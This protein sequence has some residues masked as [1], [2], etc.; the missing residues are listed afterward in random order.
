V[1]LPNFLIVGAA[2][3]GTTSLHHYLQQHPDIY[4]PAQKELHYFARDP[5]LR[6]TGGPGD[7]YVLANICRTWEE[8]ESCYA[9]AARQSAVGEISPSYLYFSEISRQIKQELRHPKIIMILRNPIEKAFSQYMHLVRDNR[10]TL[11]FH[12]GLM[13]EGERIENGWAA[14]WRYAES[15]LYRLRVQTYLDVFGERNVRIFFYDDLVRFPERLVREILEFIDV[16]P[17][18]PIDFA[19]VHN[20][21]GKPRSRLV[22]NLLTR[23]SRLRDMAKRLLPAETTY[24]LKLRLQD[25]NTGA[26]GTIDRRSRAYLREFFAEDVQALQQLVGRRLNWLD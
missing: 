20:R 7:R 26:K 25:L 6:L 18:R 17:E 4:L 13:A 22:A 21:S 11:D 12:D 2:K 10:E 16:D 23:P 1:R 15:S 5:M 8:Y 9:K 19:Q 3:S 24:L 14:I